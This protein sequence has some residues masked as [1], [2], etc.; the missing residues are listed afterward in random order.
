MAKLFQI[1]KDNRIP[2]IILTIGLFLAFF[3]STIPNLQFA[4]FLYGFLIIIALFAY[5]NPALQTYVIGIPTKGLFVKMLFGLIAGFVILIMPKFGFSLGVPLVP[6]SV[7]NTLRAL[8]ILGFAP[9]IEELS[10]K[11][12]L[13]GFIKYIA[14]KG[15]TPTKAIVWTAIFLQAVFFTIIHFTAYSQNWYSA[16]TFG[17]AWSQISAVSASLISAFIF[18][19]LMGILVTRKGIN[20]LATSITAHYLINQIIFVQIYSIFA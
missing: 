13:L 3:I 19:F 16:P 10:T 2:V 12:A 20:S 15:K 18:A 17:S 7:D 1:S 4:S 6:G 14:S 8:I 9:F 11:G 5:T